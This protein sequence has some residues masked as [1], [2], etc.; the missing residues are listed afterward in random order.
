MSEQ[1]GSKALRQWPERSSSAAHPAETKSQGPTRSYE[2]RSLPTSNSEGTVSSSLVTSVELR[3]L[4][5]LT[6]SHGR[7]YSNDCQGFVLA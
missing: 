7:A 1:S 6:S 3:R 5:L 4:E 2:G